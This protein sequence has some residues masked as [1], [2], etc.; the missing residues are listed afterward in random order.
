MTDVR[1]TAQQPAGCLEGDIGGSDDRTGTPLGLAA[2]LAGTLVGTV[3]NNVVNVPLGAI[4]DEFDAPLGNGVFVVVGFLVCFAATI[5]LAGWFGDRFGRRRIYCAALLATAACAVGAAT[6]PSLPLLIAWRSLGGV[7]AAAFAPAVM[8]LIAWM[9]SGPRRGRA[10][11]A[12]A[13]VNGIGQAVGPSLGGLV[14]DNWGW[15]W[16]FVPLVPVALAGFV[17]TLRYVPRFPGVRMPFDLAGAAALTIGSALLMLGLALVS[18]PDMPGWL[19]A[20]AVT[21]AVAALAWFVWHCAHTR[22]PFVDVRLV[23]ESR[24]VRSCLA[25]F[26]QMFCLGA[27]LLAVPLYLVGQSVSISAA[28]M[29]LF[30]V[31]ATMAVLGPLVGRWQDKLGPRR[32]LR[33]GLVLLLIAQVGM[34]V[35]VGHGRLVLGALIVVLVIGGVGISL[36]QTPAATGAT[37]SPA[38]EQGTGLGLFNLLRF[39]GSACGAASV[40]VALDLSG[41]PAVFIACAVIVALGLAGSFV[42]PDPQ[43]V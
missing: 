27:T 42:G 12:W 4:I 36:V 43:P 15:R 31:P 40:A 19:V 13:S 37:R 16:V 3:S 33:S 11:G 8:G 28:G 35:T 39:G 5:P 29:M 32:V 41:Y 10:M 38:G 26:A 17:G 24:F 34:T 22:A 7:A 6:A 1:G 2:L 14:A 25:A 30:V 21:A 9:F 20:A 18:Q 23:T